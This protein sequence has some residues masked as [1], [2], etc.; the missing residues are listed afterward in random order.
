M[1]NTNYALEAGL[2]P[3]KDAIA[4]ESAESPYANIIAVRKADQD[5]PWVATLLAA[6]Q[7]DE[8]KRFIREKF[9]DAIVPAW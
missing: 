7:N 1:I 9:K 2:D 4:R 6:Y 5:K 8:V 3:I